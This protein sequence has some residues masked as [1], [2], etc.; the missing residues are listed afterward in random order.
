MNSTL[1]RIIKEVI[2]IQD[3]KHNYCIDEN[4]YGTGIVDDYRVTFQVNEYGDILVET[5]RCYLVS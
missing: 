3:S 5:I 1:F 2:A 4:G